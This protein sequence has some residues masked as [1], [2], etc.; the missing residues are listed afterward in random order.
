[1]VLDQASEAGATSSSLP[2]RTAAVFIAIILIVV[3][4]RLLGRL[5]RRI[6]QPPVIGEILAGILLGTSLLGQFH[7]GSRTLTAVLFPADVTQILKA[8]ANLGL[9][10]FMFIIGLELDL[11]LIKGNERKA[12]VISISSILVPFAGGALLALVLYHDHAQ[13]GLAPG[14]H[15][16]KLAFALFI[17]ASMCVTAFPVLARILNERGMTRTPLGVI[18]LA[19]AA[20]DD[21]VA[22]SL[23]ALVSA[24]AG[25]TNDPL[26][27][28]LAYS[29][30]YIAVMFG[31]IRPLL[32]RY[33]VPIYQ[34]AGRLTPDVLAFLLVGL[35][36]SSWATDH[37]GIHFI[38]GAF[39]F[40]LV[41]PREGTTMLFAEILER[42]EQVSVL[43]LLPI[44]FII[45]GLS[46]DLTQLT[47][48]VLGELFAV[49]AVAI[50]G[51]FIGAYFAARAQG[52]PN[53]RSQA[54]GL[55]MNTRGLTELILLSVGLKLKVL[56]VQLFTMLVVMAVVTT[57]MT[58]P[59]LKLVYPDRIVAKEVEEA[60]REAL[61]IPNAYR[62][63]VVLG[64][65]SADAPLVSLAGDLA[66]SEQPSQVVLSL[67]RPQNTAPVEVGSGLTFELAEMAGVMGELEVLAEQIRARGI[68]CAV[69]SRFSADLTTDAISQVASTNADLVLVSP[70]ATIDHDR[71]LAAV[72]VTVGVWDGASALSAA[73]GPVAA[74]AGGGDA[75]EAAIA[76]G[77]RV[78]AVRGETLTL[79]DDGSRRR[80]SGLVERLDR[81]GVRAQITA[82]DAATEGL[83][84]L[85][86]GETAPAW[87]GA[88]LRV[89][90]S[91]LTD[92]SELAAL[93]ESGP[94][95][96]PSQEPAAQTA[97]TV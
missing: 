62:V 61:G 77:V 7:S 26:W 48:K 40:G 75:A 32:A 31:I 39:V 68:D 49:L 10:I 43:L 12:G 38:F 81:M 57:I 20:I 96:L 37:I 59:L 94:I 8:F 78:A 86:I 83:V 45:S 29:A 44:F 42:L 54:L 56:D 41:V 30:L 95:V 6:G 76:L 9:V 93:F 73:S 18:A 52:I 4:A 27:E 23:L 34:K 66:G 22:W 14:G 58:A 50:G 55:L 24:I 63:V 85:E 5:F 33:L 16:K 13:G 90:P 80:I 92:Q 70:T 53:R 15:V 65:V 46:V 69:L 67:L 97:P 88:V 35:L 71:F 17:G 89:R 11:K 19:C 21:V 79:I 84:A 74:V 72:E 36:L 51:K 82:L 64:E 28:V 25:Y 91:Q 87:A 1:M 3:L 60:E 47:G 2:D